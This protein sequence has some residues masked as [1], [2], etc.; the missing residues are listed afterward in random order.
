MKVQSS[1]QRASITRKKNKSK[2]QVQ[3][4]LRSSSQKKQRS[5]TLVGGRPNCFPHTGP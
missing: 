1:R 4:K 3:A 5:E 2:C